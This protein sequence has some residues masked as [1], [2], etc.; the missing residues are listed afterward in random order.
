ML[1]NC[2]RQCEA[3]M[4][5]HHVPDSGARVPVLGQPLLDASVPADQPKPSDAVLE[6]HARQLQP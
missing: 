1:L 2:T 4:Q 6:L 5:E 3:D